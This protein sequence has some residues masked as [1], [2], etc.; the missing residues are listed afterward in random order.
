MQDEIYEIP[1]SQ[2]RKIIRSS[3][4]MTSSRIPGFYNKSLSER[5]DEIAKSSGLSREELAVEETLLK[6]YWFELN[7]K[8]LEG[9]NIQINR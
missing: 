3:G 6:I 2:N 5:L 1:F 8:E 9:I 4:F 7:R